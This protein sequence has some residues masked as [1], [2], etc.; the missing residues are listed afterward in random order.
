MISILL[1]K[2]GFTLTE[3]LV[4]MALSA[5]VMASVGAIYY[6][7]QKSFLA[8]EQIA[9]AQQNL[10]TA[11]YFMEREIRSAGY[12]PTQKVNP[13]I[14]VANNNSITFQA[15][16]NGSEAIDAGETITYSL[17]DS[18]ADGDTDLGR[19]NGGGNRPLAENIDA[20][21]F[22]YL[23]GASPPSVLDDDGL[24][25]VTT[26]INQ[27]RSVQVTVVARTGRADPGYTDARIYTNLQGQTILG[28]QN[29]NF[30]RRSLSTT[31]SC[32]N[33]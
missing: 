20:L 15:D 21:N 19:N 10:R 28:V 3:L 26:N 30:R 17:Y 4:A 13:S 27:I 24:G 31:I 25:N 23:N 9:S 8:Q 12:D 7:Q 33:L 14:Q 1:D 22:I 18:G 5:I 2:R 16:I 11:M 29:D 32:R 6:Q